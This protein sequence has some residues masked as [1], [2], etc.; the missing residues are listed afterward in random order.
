M[1]PH[2]QT[3]PSNMVGFSHSN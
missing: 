2:T 1:P 3:Y